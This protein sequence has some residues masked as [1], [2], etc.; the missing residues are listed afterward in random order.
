MIFQDTTMNNS[1]KWMDEVFNSV[2]EKMK[3]DGC[4]LKG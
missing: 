1:A 3:T 2:G 4:E